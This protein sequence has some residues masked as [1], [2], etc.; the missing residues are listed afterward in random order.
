M[1]YDSYT[2][3]CVK[4]E[5][6]NDFGKRKRAILN[7]FDIDHSYL[8]L[9]EVKCHAYNKDYAKMNTNS[10]ETAV[11]ALGYKNGTVRLFHSDDLDQM[12]ETPCKVL[13]L[14]V[15]IIDM[16]FVQNGRSLNLVTL[17]TDNKVVFTSL[18][19]KQILFEKELPYEPVKLVVDPNL[20]F[21]LVTVKAQ[22]VES[23]I[24]EAP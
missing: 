1:V 21:I 11:I 12:I 7:N 5:E 10:I 18:R 8:T 9:S 23:E 22:A 6:E 2:I 16:V 17:H 4:C 15:D 14:K 24:L 13:D 3:E 19:T 20:N